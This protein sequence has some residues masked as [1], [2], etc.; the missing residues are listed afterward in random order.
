MIRAL[1][2][3]ALVLG[4]G[5][6]SGQ[7][8]CVLPNTLTAGT[9]ASASQVMANFNA[10]NACI[11]K[12]NMSLT[13]AAGPLT[14][15]N[16]TETMIGLAATFTP[17]ASGNIFIYIQ[18]QC[19]NT[20]TGDGVNQTLRFGTGTAPVF[21]AA[22]TGTVVN[23]SSLTEANGNAVFSCNMAG[24]VTGLTIATPIWIDESWAALTGGTATIV[25]MNVQVFEL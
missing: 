23:T 6:G 25:R 19:A 1:L 10:L 20:V 21:G 4:L 14:T 22:I 12:S 3:I 7:A 5:V 24:I 2:A 17:V 15:V 13:P 16:G 18:A 8:A 11:N 9:L